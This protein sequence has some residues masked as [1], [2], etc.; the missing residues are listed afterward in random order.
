[1]KTGLVLEG[2]GIRGIFTN[3]VLDFFLDEKIVFDY[4]IGVSAG[5]LNAYAYI[6]SV[7]SLYKNVFDNMDKDSI[8]GTK[9]FLDSGKVINFEKMF[10]DAVDK[11]NLDFKKVMKSNIEWE[12][13]CSNLRSGKANYFSEHKDLRRIKK[14]S[15]ASCSLPFIC[16]VCFLDGGYYLDG[17]ICDSIPVQR[18]LDMGCDKVV[19]ICTRRSGKHPSLPFWQLELARTTYKKFPFFIDAMVNREKMYLNEQKL[20]NKLEKEGKAIVIR[21]TIE[22]IGRL[23]QNKE[24]VN[25]FYMHGYDSAKNKLENIKSFLGD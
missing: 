12:V 20:I 23:E 3:G 16:D 10:S 2:G 1:M 15:T 4:V 7:R 5:S 11:H 17:G 9:E 14:I 6:S 22:E 24:K 25:N 13:V 21:P 19:V 18:A 8:Y